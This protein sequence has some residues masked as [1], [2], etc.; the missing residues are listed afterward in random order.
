MQMIWT[1]I[2]GLLHESAERPAK[3]SIVDGQFLLTTQFELDDK[4]KEFL[5][6]VNT[7]LLRS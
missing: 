3:I 4:K 7:Y 5:R 1:L 2:F 6:T